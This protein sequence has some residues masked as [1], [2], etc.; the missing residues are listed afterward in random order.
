MRRRT[1]AGTCGRVQQGMQ[2]QHAYCQLLL[3]LLDIHG[4]FSCQTALFG[5][6]LHVKRAV[7]SLSLPVERARSIP[8]AG[9][10][11]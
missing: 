3:Y 8:E 7:T 6:V 9:Q 4:F 10:H 5:L 1:A 11:W 2:Q